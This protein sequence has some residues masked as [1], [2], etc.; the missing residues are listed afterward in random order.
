MSDTC[1]HDCPADGMDMARYRRVLWFALIVNLAMFAVEVLASWHS[2][3][4]SLLADAI[5]FGG[6][7]ANYA[8]SLIALS[9][10]PVWRTRV[11]FLKGLGMM[12]FGLLV[13]ANAAWALWHGK[14]PDAYTMSV[15]SILAFT[16]NLAVAW[17]L[18]AFREGDA[19]MRSV[20][21]CSRNDALA[22]LAVLLAA[23]GVM[24]TSQAWPDLAV[25]AIMAGL[26]LQGGWSVLAQ[27]RRETTANA[28]H[29]HSH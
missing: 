22:N 19:N 23:L 24:G 20:W 17:R 1:D 28:S 27:A 13:L 7:A 26:A 3:S 4:Q 11:A 16:C 18:Y 14:V 29:G 10:A 21:L 12:G 2:H 6:D 9:Y 15:I 25:A 5:D 8:V